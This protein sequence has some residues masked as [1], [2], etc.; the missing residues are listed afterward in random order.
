MLNRTWA[1]GFALALTA[2][3]LAA[4][5]AQGGGGGAGAAAAGGVNDAGPAAT[6]SPRSTIGHDAMGGSG[7]RSNTRNGSNGTS[8]ASAKPGNSNSANAHADGVNSPQ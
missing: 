3:P 6:D 1:I 8:T 4:A 7:M 2:A 5:L